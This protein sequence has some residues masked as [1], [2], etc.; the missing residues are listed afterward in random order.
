[1]L[2]I[3]SNIMYR[4]RCTAFYSTLVKVAARCK[5]RA[6]AKNNTCAKRERAIFCRLN[7]L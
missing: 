2:K 6:A 3:R 5:T 1:M 4:L 7:T